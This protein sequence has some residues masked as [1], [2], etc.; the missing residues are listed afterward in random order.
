MLNKLNSNEYKQCI[1]DIVTKDFS[2]ILNN[3]KNEV[4]QAQTIYR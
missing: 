1:A 2:A 3:L 4:N